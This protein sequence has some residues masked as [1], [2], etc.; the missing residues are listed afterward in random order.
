MNSVPNHKHQYTCTHRSG[1]SCYNQCRGVRITQVTKN[2]TENT[3]R[4][5]HRQMYIQKVTYRSFRAENYLGTKVFISEDLWA[6]KCDNIYQ[7]RFSIC[8]RSLISKR[9]T[10]TRWMH[11]I[12]INHIKDTN[13]SNQQLSF[14]P[15]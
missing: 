4:Q 1:S 13:N 3:Y 2:S 15:I 12:L 7:L 14:S 9:E 6:W 8:Y 11:C 5:A 10:V